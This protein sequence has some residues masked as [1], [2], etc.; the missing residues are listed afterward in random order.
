M[1]EISLIQIKRDEGSNS[2]QIVKSLNDLNLV[3]KSF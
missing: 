3:S 1:T 2:L